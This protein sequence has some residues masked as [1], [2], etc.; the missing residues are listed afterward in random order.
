MDENRKIPYKE[1]GEVK[2]QKTA[3]Y[4]DAEGTVRQLNKK[5]EELSRYY[6]MS[7]EQAKASLDYHFFAKE[8]DGVTKSLR[9]SL[10]MENAK[11]NNLHIFVIDFDDH[12][13]TTPFYKAAAVAADY[14]TT[15]QSGGH[16]MFF[17]VNKEKAHPLF[18][19]INLLTAKANAGLEGGWVSKTGCITL[20][21][22]N[23]VDFFCDSCRLIYE[24]EEWDNTRSLTDKTAVVYELIKANFNLNR[25]K[26]IDI[27]ADAR[28][29]NMV[30]HAQTAEQIRADM[31]MTDRKCAVFDDLIENISSDVEKRE[32]LKVGFDIYAAFVGD[33]EDD[34]EFNVDLGGSIFL[35]W[36][37]LAP[38]RFQPQSCAS[39][40]A[41]I[42]SQGEGGN[43]RLKNEKWHDILYNAFWQLSEPEPEPE[44]T[45]EEKAA[46]TVELERLWFVLAMELERQKAVE[47]ERIERQNV[48][49]TAELE[50]QKNEP[51]PEPTFRGRPCHWVSEPRH[52]EGAQVGWSHLI[53]YDGKNYAQEAF[54]K[55]MFPEYKK[56]NKLVTF[57]NPDLLYLAPSRR[58]KLAY[59]V[60]EYEYGLV[61]VAQKDED[62]LRY[63]CDRSN[64]RAAGQLGSRLYWAND[65]NDSAHSLARLVSFG[66]RQSQKEAAK[67]LWCYKEER[68]GRC[69]TFRSEPLNW[70]FWLGMVETQMNIIKN[71]KFDGMNDLI[72][73]DAERQKRAESAG[74]AAL[75]YQGGRHL[76]LPGEM[77]G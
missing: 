42:C 60:L 39:T 33:D 67:G 6:H 72:K 38:A 1:N 23:K 61:D 49:Y 37:K 65:N 58:E 48:K 62:D 46:R 9:V 68:N 51:D 4:V 76:T 14:I 63:V 77:R 43:A 19:S 24:F 7:Y 64:I 3:K 40:W 44:P 8:Y 75:Y 29:K 15:S 53:Q 13:T 18:D 34:Y 26:E 69:I 50:R 22:K 73:T 54:F 30:L 5:S 12:D 47:A 57:K 17:G 66:T 32:W 45:E 52:Q 21:G 71:G 10:W 41:W 2:Y 56:H 16:H 25:P 55:S 70:D 36:S 20:D 35:Y 74:M 27:F 59:E 11:Y 28:Y 31:Q